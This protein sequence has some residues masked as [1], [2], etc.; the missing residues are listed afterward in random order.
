MS[1]A[2]PE[3]QVAKPDRE[4][5][6][7][8]S[9][10][11]DGDQCITITL[12]YPH[13]CALDGRAVKTL[14]GAILLTLGRTSVRTLESSVLHMSSAAKFCQPVLFPNTPNQSFDLVININS[15]LKREKTGKP[16]KRGK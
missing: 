10:S 1:R 13:A 16:I 9:S 8:S 12:N 4:D 5:L 3:L 15:T 11:H 7:G 2:E 6:H 14:A